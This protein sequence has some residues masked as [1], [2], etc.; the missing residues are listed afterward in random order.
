MKARFLGSLILGAFAAAVVTGYAGSYRHAAL[1]A[2]ASRNHQTAGFI[3][4]SGFIG[5]TLFVAVIVFVFA[6]VFAARPRRQRA[7][8][9]RAFQGHP[10][11]RRRP[12]T[13]VWR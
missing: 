5:L 12:R 8:A 4:M 11:S 3:L 9:G 10:V 2:S 1:A 13:D 6:T 7:D